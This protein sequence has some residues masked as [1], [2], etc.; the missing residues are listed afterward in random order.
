VREVLATNDA[1]KRRYMQESSTTSI[2][3]RRRLPSSAEKR[4]SEVTLMVEVR[5][6]QWLFPLVVNTHT[7][8]KQRIK[9]MPVESAYHAEWQAEYRRRAQRRDRTSRA[10]ALPAWKMIR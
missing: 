8:G 5:R 3:G 1:S 7:W 6:R 2:P 10:A 4:R 9:E